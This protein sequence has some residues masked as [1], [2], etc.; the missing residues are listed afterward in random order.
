MLKDANA[1]KGIFFLLLA[2]LFFTVATVFSKLLTGMSTISAIEV[3]FARFFLGLIVV[4]AIVCRDSVSLVPNRPALLIWRGVLNTVAVILFFLASQH[5]TIT[6]THM[7]NMTYPFFI[8]LFSPLLFRREKISP[9][10]YPLLMVALVGI[11]LVINPDLR[12][13]NRGDVYALMSA[14]VGAFAIMTL[15]LARRSDS[16]MV[17]LFYLM[18]IGPYSTDWPCCRCLSCRREDSGHS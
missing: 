1:Y 11:W 15:N 8:F 18:L 9:F 17:I 13:I 16:T 12:A 10:F 5:T 7:L 4:G 14:V 6:N 3:T 2:E